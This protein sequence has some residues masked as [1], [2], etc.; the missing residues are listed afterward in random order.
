M[1][2]RYKDTK[3]QRY[4]GT[5]VQRV[6][7]DGVIRRLMEKSDIKAEYNSNNKALNLCIFKYLN[8]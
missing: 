8:N 4:N 7:T 2:Q 5:M 1:V 6:M 3:V